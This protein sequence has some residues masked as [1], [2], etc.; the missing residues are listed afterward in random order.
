[1]K[2]ELKLSFVHNEIEITLYTFFIAILQF[3]TSSEIYM[4]VYMHAYTL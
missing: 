4:H 3:S 1:M 2:L